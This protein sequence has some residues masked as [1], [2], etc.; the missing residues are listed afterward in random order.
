MED[1]RRTTCRLYTPKPPHGFKWKVRGERG[2]APGTAVFTPKPPCVQPCA[3][4]PDHVRDCK[5]AT[6]RSP[7]PTPKPCRI[8]YPTRNPACPENPR[9][10]PRWPPPPTIRSARRK[11]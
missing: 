2:T 1:K 7:R 3:P 8:E 9:P 11:R 10:P 6:P 4:A 5:P